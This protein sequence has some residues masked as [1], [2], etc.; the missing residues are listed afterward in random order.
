MLVFPAV[1]LVGGAYLVYKNLRRDYVFGNIEKTK[2]DSLSAQ[3]TEF[4]GIA[5]CQKPLQSHVT[6]QNCVYSRA[7]VEYEGTESRWRPIVSVEKKAPFFVEDDS[8][9][10]AIDPSDADFQISGPSTFV[11][12]SLHHGQKGTI[13]ASILARA[14]AT[15]VL[16][17]IVLPNDR[18]A[19]D[20]TALDALLENPEARQKMATYL[21]KPLRIKEYT[22]PE[23]TKLYLV[24][25]A[26]ESTAKP[27]LISDK[28][29]ARLSLREKAYFDIFKGACLIALSL[30]TAFAVLS[31]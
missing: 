6:K 16:R 3:P 31:A 24:G 7:T 21:T 23:G 15:G 17:G 5:R 14:G 10:V 22:I 9:R 28:E 29:S 30:L 4:S 19:I 12:C 8:G 26:S 11:G 18:E 27:M 1:V 2:I 20:E 13:G 25:G